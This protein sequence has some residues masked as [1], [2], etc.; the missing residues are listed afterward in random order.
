MN[1]I[2]DIALR[3]RHLFQR[4]L[5]SLPLPA[6]LALPLSCAAAALLSALGYALYK[7][8]RLSHVPGPFWTPYSFFRLL[9]RGRLYEEFPALS[10]KYGRSPI[11][12]VTPHICGYW[13]LAT[14]TDVSPL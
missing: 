7:W 1:A 6:G 8:H 13:W 3:V 9:A 11:L 10:E 2:T 4:G 14:P 12:L 5:R